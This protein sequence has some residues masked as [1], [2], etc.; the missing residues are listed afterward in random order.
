MHRVKIP[1]ENSGR[2][3]GSKLSPPERRGHRSKWPRRMD[4][5]FQ[6]SK[7]AA[8]DKVP[9]GLV[10]RIGGEILIVLSVFGF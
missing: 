7:V 4:L 9:I 2:T 1:L 10:E 6:R 5:W 3:E 8:V